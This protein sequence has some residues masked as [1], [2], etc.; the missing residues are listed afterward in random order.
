MIVLTSDDFIDFV[1]SY[2]PKMN[3]GVTYDV[4]RKGSGEVDQVV[5][6]GVGEVVWRFA[7]FDQ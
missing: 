7:H 2:V 6:G 4:S 3:V 5:I 1:F